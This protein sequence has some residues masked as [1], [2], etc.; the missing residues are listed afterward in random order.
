MG[1]GEEPSPYFICTNST[2]RKVQKNVPRQH[3]ICLY[4]LRQK[5]L[6][7]D[8]CYASEHLHLLVFLISYEM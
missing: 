4:L 7:K 2:E 8:T 3:L 1:A 6:S 5:Y